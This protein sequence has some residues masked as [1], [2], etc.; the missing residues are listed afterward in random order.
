MCDTYV[1]ISFIQSKWFTILVKLYVRRRDNP[2]WRSCFTGK[3]IITRDM[4]HFIFESGEI[5]Y[6]FDKYWWN[7]KGRYC[8]SR[9][10]VAVTQ[11]QQI[12]S[13][14]FKRITIFIVCQRLETVR[15][16]KSLTTEITNFVHY[17]AWAY[18]DVTYPSK[19]NY[20]RAG[21]MT[22]SVNIN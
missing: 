2:V 14:R 8:R 3:T 10:E 7:I 12:G 19:L 11:N 6:I 20:F 22:R 1:S 4:Q 21:R 16:E 15:R 13:G 5:I 18:G 9:I 17:L